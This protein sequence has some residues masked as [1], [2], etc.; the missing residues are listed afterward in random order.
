MEPPHP[1]REL[2][3]LAKS[4]TVTDG[5]DQRGCGNRTDAGYRYKP[6]AGLILMSS[7]M[8]HSVSLVDPY[9]HL[10]EFQLQLREQHTQCAG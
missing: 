10:I 7:L 9:R 3:S 5:L 6:L 1:G 2:P 8:E 4:C